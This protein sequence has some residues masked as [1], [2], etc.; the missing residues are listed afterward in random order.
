MKRIIAALLAVMMVC[1]L[2][3]ACGDGDDPNRTVKTTVE[4]KY[5]EGFAK[6]YARSVE[7]DDNGNTTYEFSGSKYDEFVYDYRNNVAKDISS[8]IASKHESTYGQYAYI[9]IDRKAVIVGLNPGEYDAA[10]AEAEAP[11]YAESAFKVFQNLETPES[12][13]SVIFCNANDQN[14]VYG[15]FEFT[16][17]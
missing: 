3:A 7:T 14:E 16:A 6:N 8:E 12:T 2:L 17:E 5:D 15:S 4:S 9:N 10:T 11:S 13:I 1:A